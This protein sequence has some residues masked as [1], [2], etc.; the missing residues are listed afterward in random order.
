[1]STHFLQKEE[2]CHLA[3]VQRIRSCEG[4]GADGEKIDP[5]HMKEVLEFQW[6]AFT[7]RAI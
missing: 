4:L 5:E 3:L 2:W 7:S 1:M 6:H